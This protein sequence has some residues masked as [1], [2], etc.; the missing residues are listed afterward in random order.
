VASIN[1]RG[2]FVAALV[3]ALTA[4][5]GSDDGGDSPPA[6]PPPP[7]PAAVKVGGTVSGLSGALVLRDNGADD[8]NVASDGAFTFATSLG[9]GVAYNVSVA[10][11]PANQTCTVTNGTGTTGTANVTNVAVACAANAV[12]PPSAL[13]YPSPQ[14]FSLGAAITPINPT[15]T[16][17]VTSY[18][19]SPAL[20]AGLA[21]DS[22]TGQITGTPTAESASA[23][24]VISATNSGGSTNFALAIAVIAPGSFT[25]GGTVTGLKGTGLV[26]RNNGGNDL[27]I[28]ASG[29]MT[30]STPVATDKTYAV[31]VK[32]QP[33]HPGQICT[34]MNGK[35]EVGVANVTDVVV[36]CVGSSF[37]DTDRDGLTDEIEAM[38]G[39]DPTKVDSDSDRLG[40]GEEVLLRG[41][42]PLQID[43]DSDS[44]DDSSEVANGTAPNNFDTDG[45][46]IDDGLDP[47][48]WR[49]DGDGDGLSD[50]I[51]PSP[52]LR[53]A[54]GGGASDGA[55]ALAGTNPFLPGDDRPS[56]DS[57]HDFL[58]DNDEFAL[59]TDPFDAD[60]D[61]DLVMDGLEVGTCDPLVFD[62][63][64]D[65]HKDG[66][67]RATRETCDQPDTDHDGLADNEE[68]ATLTADADEDGLIDGVEE[69]VY[70]SHD[71]VQDSD[72]DGINDG[73]EVK[74]HLTDP[75]S[76]DTD[77]DGIKDGQEIKSG[78]DPVHG[79]GGS[80]CSI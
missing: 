34:V 25:I 40:D 78:T 43:T 72:N 36:D 13:S 14:S 30:F 7:P 11:Q 32:I 19:V 56:I 18:A 54:D 46:G 38:L 23:N 64:G 68:P 44:V 50:D 41:T 29:A 21:L 49:A 73:D 15:V 45:D 26:L 66:L 51:D 24:F 17:A 80:T 28:T 48:P 31:V 8:L 55:E 62:T 69:R 47:Y 1:L 9:A 3:L 58:D 2:G 20:P 74:I 33:V 27:V 4:C 52:L 6:P 53:D 63:D 37:V 22:S 42:D 79:P 10:T 61:N 77:C 70:H 12:P 39:T 76:A 5:G 71:G 59:G 57:D 75:A 35:G 16:G 67:E 65:T 60:T